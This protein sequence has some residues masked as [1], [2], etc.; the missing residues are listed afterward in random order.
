MS[1]FPQ[2]AICG[3]SGQAE[4]LLDRSL[5]FR[6]SA[7]AYLTRTPSSAGNRKTFTISYWHKKAKNAGF[8]FEARNSSG[9]AFFALKTTGDTFN[10]RS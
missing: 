2:P 7:S 3:A 10:T 5:R 4:Y 1:L 8:L 6:E 9:G